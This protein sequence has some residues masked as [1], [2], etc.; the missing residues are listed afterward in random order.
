M[1]TVTVHHT[2]KA[3]IEAVFEA[4]TNSTRLPSVLG[5]GIR[6]VIPA[7][8]PDP[9]G[10]GA[11]R[12]VNAWPVWF[13]EEITRFERPYR[14]DYHIL[15]VRPH[16]EHLDGKFL[17]E[18]VTGGTRVTWTTSVRFTGALAGLKSAVAGPV[19][20]LAFKAVLSAVGIMMMK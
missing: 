5:Q 15:E 1:K 16:F 10:V 6:I 9:D 20:A 18:S 19:T 8:G 17:F 2:F 3:P 4:V 11:I 13:R 14:M 12:E 7:A